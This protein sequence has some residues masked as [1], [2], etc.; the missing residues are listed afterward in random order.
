MELAENA[1]SELP[2]LHLNLGI[3]FERMHADERAEAEFRKDIAIEPDLADNYEQLGTLFL[4]MERYEDAERSYREALQRD[5]RKPAAYFG[6]AKIQQQQGKYQEALKAIN[7]ALRLAPD[8]ASV[9]YVRGRILGRL[10]RREEA[11]VEFATVRKLLEKS[12]TK[13]VESFEE[14]PVPNPELAREPQP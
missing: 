12:L 6:L 7:E 5:A 10:G 9:H 1:N 14:R 4:R 13:D 8:H 3:A 2:F 11:D